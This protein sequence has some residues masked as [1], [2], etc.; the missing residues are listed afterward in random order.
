MILNTRKWDYLLSKWKQIVWGSKD[1][2]LKDLGK[3]LID[4]AEWLIGQAEKQ[5]QELEK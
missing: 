3:E 4:E 2:W 1:V 5:I